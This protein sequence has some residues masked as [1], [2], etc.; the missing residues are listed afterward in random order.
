[1][2]SSHCHFVGIHGNTEL[3]AALKLLVCAG[4]QK[5]NLFLKRI[6]CSKYKQKGIVKVQISY[7]MQ[8]LQCSIFKIVTC[9]AFVIYTKN[10]S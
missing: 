7:Q 2:C 3:V 10:L 9:E 6:R 8:N 4:T 5:F 1:M